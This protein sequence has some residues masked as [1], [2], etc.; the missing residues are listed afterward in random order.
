MIAKMRLS[1]R[2]VNDFKI[3]ILKSIKKICPNRMRQ[4]CKNQRLCNGFLFKISIEED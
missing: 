1:K 2:E 4:K 3:H